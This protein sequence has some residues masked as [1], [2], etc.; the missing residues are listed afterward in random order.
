M[1]P[2]CRRL[3]WTTASILST[4][5]PIFS[6][7][8]N[9]AMRWPSGCWPAGTS[10]TSSASLVSPA[11]LWPS[12]RASFTS[13]ATRWMSPT[14][15]CAATGSIRPSRLG[16]ISITSSETTV[17][18]RGRSTY[19]VGPR[20][21]TL[22]GKSFYEE[23]VHADHSVGR[24]R[25][26]GLLGLGRVLPQPGESNS[27]AA[28]DSGTGGVV[29]PEGRRVGQG[30]VRDAAGGLLHPRRAGHD[31]CAGLAGRY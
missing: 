10:C 21:T 9:G 18:W 6:T 26:A 11:R 24:P 17:A 20:A 16:R 15:C 27:Q 12:I 28:G 4:A 13:T 22:S 25:R 7:N 23:V 2:A 3:T 29:L 1:D 14:S 19:R 8:P 31:H 30:V 5:W